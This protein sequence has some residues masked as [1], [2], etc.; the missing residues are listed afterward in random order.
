MLPALRGAHDTMPPSSFKSPCPNKTVLLQTCWRRTQML[1]KLS[2]ALLIC[3]PN[4]VRQHGKW[5]SWQ[6][7]G[8]HVHAGIE[9]PSTSANCLQVCTLIGAEY[10]GNPDHT[11]KAGNWVGNVWEMS[12][13]R[14][15]WHSFPW[16][17]CHRTHARGKTHL[18]WQ[19]PPGTDPAGSRASALLRTPFR[20]KQQLHTCS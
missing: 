7:Y 6:R 15:G 18:L 8:L 5:E 1:S 9:A 3:A 12:W 13:P 14:M 10:I 19:L 2:H 17:F 11:A 20:R 4:R 16:R